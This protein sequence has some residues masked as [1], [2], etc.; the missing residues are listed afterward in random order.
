MD[1]RQST[2]RKEH[3]VF[4]SHLAHCFNVC[5]LYKAM[6]ITYLQP[7]GVHS[8]QISEISIDLEGLISSFL[9]LLKHTAGLPL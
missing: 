9:C 4:V 2:I 5:P 1:L 7:C 6:H 3:A 8:G